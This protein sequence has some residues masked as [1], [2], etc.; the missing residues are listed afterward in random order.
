VRAV[1]VSYDFTLKNEPYYHARCA[2]MG[3]IGNALQQRIS[4]LQQN[5]HP[6]WKEV[7][8]NTD[9]GVALW[10][11]DSCAWPAP[12]PQTTVATVKP[13][14]KAAP[15]ANN[16]PQLAPAAGMPDKQ[17]VNTQNTSLLRHTPTVHQD[18][19]RLQNEL[20]LIVDRK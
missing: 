17:P 5:G 9:S 13:A 20:L 15:V 3:R 10:K 2:E 8:L 14:P 19:Q 1:L 4:Y 16:L 18:T 6:K 11:R 7:D 12:K